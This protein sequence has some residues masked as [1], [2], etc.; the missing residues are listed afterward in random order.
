MKTSGK[1]IIEK[2]RRIQKIMS[3]RDAINLLNLNSGAIVDI[4]LSASTGQ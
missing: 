3:V 4:Y 2:I 1:P